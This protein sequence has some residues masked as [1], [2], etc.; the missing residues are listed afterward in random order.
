MVKG[1]VGSRSPFPPPLWGS[2]R[3]RPV[4]AAQ[5]AAETPSLPE[6]RKPVPLPPGQKEAENSVKCHNKRPPSAEQ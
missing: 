2:G 3:L 5:I 1:C 6:T 4:T